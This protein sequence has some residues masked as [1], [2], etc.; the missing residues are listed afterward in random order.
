M[1]NDFDKGDKSIYTVRKGFSLQ[2]MALVKLEIS[3]P[4]KEN[5]PLFYTTQQIK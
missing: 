5:G 2:Q 1:S 4:K 3:M